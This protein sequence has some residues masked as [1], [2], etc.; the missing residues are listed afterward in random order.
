MRCVSG[1][2]STAWLVTVMWFRAGL[3]DLFRWVI[4]RV[5]RQRMSGDL[6]PEADIGRSLV[7]LLL[8]PRA[9][10]VLRPYR[11]IGG[12]V[13]SLIMGLTGLY[14]IFSPAPP[15]KTPAAPRVSRPAAKGEEDLP[16]FKTN[17][18]ALK[19]RDGSG[20]S[21]SASPYTPALL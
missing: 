20:E 4:A 6:R 18:P 14:L 10:D 3:C 16:E 12:L 7:P 17:V 21:G 15:K 8:E 9:P 5:W 2:P 11:V 1:M 19:P 13:L